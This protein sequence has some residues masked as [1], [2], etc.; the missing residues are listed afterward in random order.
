MLAPDKS[1]W[2]QT[3]KERTTKMTLILQTVNITI[4][5]D[6]TVRIV[7]ITTV[8]TV[9]NS[10]VPNSTVPRTGV[11]PN[12]QTDQSSQI[13]E[14]ATSVTSQIA[15][16]ESTQRTNERRPERKSLLN[17]ANTLLTILAMILQSKRKL[18][19]NL[20]TLPFLLLF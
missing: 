12:V 2:L 11:T 15:A 16:H 18:K 6:T 13:R 4:K 8:L 10:T 1:L 14:P 7:R 20:I 19:T 9:L 3:V 5:T 17:T